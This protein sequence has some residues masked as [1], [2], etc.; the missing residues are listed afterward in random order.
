MITGTILIYDWMSNVLFD[1]VSTYSCLFV[2]FAYDFERMCDFLDAP[3]HV[4]TL[5]GESIIVTHVYRA[6]PILFMGF[7]TWVDLVILDMINFDI[8]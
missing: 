2:I 4:S 8:I 7:H 1:M 5:V 6:C 3:I